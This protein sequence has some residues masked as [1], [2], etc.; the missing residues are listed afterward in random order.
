MRRAVKYDYFREKSNF[1]AVSTMGEP[2]AILECPLCK[3]FVYK[4]IMQEN[5]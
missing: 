4:L 3:D 5:Q 1:M 2:S